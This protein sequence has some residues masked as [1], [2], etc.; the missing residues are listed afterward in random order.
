[1]RGTVLIALLLLVATPN[2]AVPRGGPSVAAARLGGPELTPVGAERAGNARGTIPAWT[3]G[4]SEP[5]ADYVS[6]KPHPD[7]FAAD[8]VLFRITADNLDEHAEHLSEGQKG[9]LRAHPETYRLD[10]YPTRRSAA[11]PARVYEAIARNAR[12]ALLVTEGKGSVR[13]ASVSSPFPIPESGLEVVWNHLLRFRGRR[14]NRMLATAAVTRTGDYRIAL[15]LQEIA[16]PYAF[17]DG[18]P[19]KERFKNMLMAIKGKSIA[20]AML[21]GEGR[22]VIEPIDRTH[23]PRKVWSYSRA[24]RR[25]V[26]LPYFAYDFPEPNS[27]G[28]RT[29][30]DVDLFTGAPDRFEWKLLGKREVYIPYNAYRLHSNDLSAEDIL[31]RSHVNPDVVRYELHRA[32]VV[33]GTL[34]PDAS[35]IYS[36]R[37]FYIDEDSWQIAL[38]DSYDRQ[39]RL[40]RLAEAHALN[41]Y[42]VPVLWETLTVYYDLQQRRY[43]AAGVDNSRRVYQFSDEANTREFTPNALNY[44]VR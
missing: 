13:N 1:M 40:W 5:P 16:F 25:I 28:L 19:F 20:P 26:R 35:H 7:P 3:G 14:V 34:R 32:W 21:V 36:R 38:A 44:Y 8:E 24:L 23:S 29:V 30:D 27:D 31:A 17:P 10:V 22:L 6:G 42:E 15:E 4:I 12:E 9:L 37:V 33:E 11:Y 43:F 18:S 2:G 41:Y 39:G